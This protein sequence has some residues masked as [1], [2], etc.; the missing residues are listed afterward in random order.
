VT[1]VGTCELGPTPGCCILSL[2]EH[3]HVDNSKKLAF[4]LEDPLKM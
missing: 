1:L 3:I 2:K 4:P